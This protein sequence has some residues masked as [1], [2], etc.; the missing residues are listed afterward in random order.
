MLLLDLIR[1][2]GYWSIFLPQRCNGNSPGVGLWPF[3]MDCQYLLIQRKGC[4]FNRPKYAFI[5]LIYSNIHSTHVKY[6]YHYSTVYKYTQIFIVFIS[7]GLLS[8]KQQLQ[9]I[10]THFWPIL[11]QKRCQQPN[12]S[13]ATG[14]RKRKRGPKASRTRSLCHRAWQKLLLPDKNQFQ[15][16]K[17]TGWLAAK[18]MAASKKLPE[19]SELTV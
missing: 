13:A 1:I 2:H 5:V 16:C 11:Q 9:R 19:A 14:A 7:A 4:S 15:L 8:L 6:V 12:R 3:K 17:W 10:R 18:L